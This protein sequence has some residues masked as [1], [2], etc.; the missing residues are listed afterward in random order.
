MTLALRPLPPRG[1]PDAPQAADNPDVN[2][3]KVPPARRLPK[4]S[5]AGRGLQTSALQPEHARRA[6]ARCSRSAP[7]ARGL[8][9][10]GPVVLDLAL[11]LGIKGLIPT[12]AVV[13]TLCFASGCS[14]GPT[15]GVVTGVAYPCVGPHRTSAQLANIPV[16]VTIRQRSKVIARETV[17]GSHTYRFDMPPGQ[18][19]VSSRTSGPT[20]ITLHAGEVDRTNLPSFCK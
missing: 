8:G 9:V 15:T 5:T 4:A 13:L 2:R 16:R 3:P 14:S 1:W 11:V 20:S 18:Y 12:A 17:R 19:V 7:R 6:R 10:T